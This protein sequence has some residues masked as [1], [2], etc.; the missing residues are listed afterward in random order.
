MNKDTIY[1]IIK[2]HC[3]MDN[4]TGYHV[5]GMIWKDVKG[6]NREE[7]KKNKL[8]QKKATKTLTDEERA[9]ALASYLDEK[10]LAKEIS[11]AEIAQLKDVFNLKQK[12]RDVIIN[13]VNYAPNNTDD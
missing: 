12:D 13:V 2:Q 1:G 6:W 10:L 3:D 7:L 11:A 4:K 8:E 5:A 9:D